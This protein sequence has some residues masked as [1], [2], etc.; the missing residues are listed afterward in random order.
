MIA[1]M[2]KLSENPS[3]YGGSFYYAFFKDQENNSYKSC[4]ATNCRNYKNWK[5]IIS[6]FDE[7][8]GCWVDGLVTKGPGLVD[9]DSNPRL[10]LSP[11]E[12]SKQ[13]K[14]EF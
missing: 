5:E 7:S 11:S 9:A 1:K 14:L 8:T 2:I 13:I 6:N 3:K 4:I 10:C 12:Q